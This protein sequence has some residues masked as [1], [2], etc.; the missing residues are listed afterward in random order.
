MVS[1]PQVSP[2]EPCAHLSPPPYVPHAQ[3]IS[4]FSIRGITLTIFNVALSRTF[5]APPPPKEQE[6]S[7][8]FPFS[9]R[10]DGPHRRSWTL[11]RRIK[12]LYPTENRTLISQFMEIIM[13]TLY[14]TEKIVFSRYKDQSVSAG[15]CG[16]GNVFFFSLCVV[17]NKYIHSRAKICL[18]FTARIL[19]FYV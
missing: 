7:P 10:L 1:F 13:Y 17:G 6:K 8:W 19:E 9:K 2:P 14:L 16:G 11:W 5:N 4:F 18:N 12:P 15:Q 3:S